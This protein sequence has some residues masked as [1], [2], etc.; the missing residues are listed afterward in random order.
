MNFL[1]EDELFDW[2]IVMNFLIENE[3]FG[4]I[5]IMLVD[6][7]SVKDSSGGRPFSVDQ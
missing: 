1:I 2:H 7:V 4:S 5:L 3:L 6:D